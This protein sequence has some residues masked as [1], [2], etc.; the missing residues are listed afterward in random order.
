MA[1]VT[2]REGEL[3]DTA[4]RRFSRKVDDEKILKEYRDRQHFMKPSM[5]RREAKKAAMRKQELKNRKTSQMINNFE[6]K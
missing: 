2:I 6:R 4:I 5:V 3:L 1:H